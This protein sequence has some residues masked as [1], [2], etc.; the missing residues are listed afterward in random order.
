MLSKGALP[1]LPSAPAPFHCAGTTSSRTLKILLSSSQSCPSDEYI[2]CSSL[3]E[4]CNI[5]STV[6][7]GYMSLGIDG[8]WTLTP[9]T[10]ENEQN[11]GYVIIIHLLHIYTVNHFNN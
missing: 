6:S 2:E 3:G 10:N 4:I 5:P 8:L 1:S 11:F 7:Q 9:F